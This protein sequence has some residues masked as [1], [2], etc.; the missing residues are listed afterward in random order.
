MEHEVILLGLKPYD[1]TDDRGKHIAGASAWV[2]PTTSQRDSHGLLPI[3]Y[4]IPQ[5]HV[6]FLA[7]QKL[8]ASAILHLDF[9]LNTGKARYSSFSNLAPCDLVV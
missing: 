2:L 1:F 4:S 6:A 5:D 7:Q 8:P 3:K 9:D